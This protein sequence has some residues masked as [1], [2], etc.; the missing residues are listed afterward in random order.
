MPNMH[1]R[2]EECASEQLGA[3]YCENC[4]VFHLDVGPVIVSFA[5]HEFAA[6]LDELQDAYWQT[7]MRGQVPMPELEFKSLS[8][9]A[10]ALGH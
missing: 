7:A 10:L 1:F 8:G 5:P 6:F 9:A 2:E 3:H 4:R